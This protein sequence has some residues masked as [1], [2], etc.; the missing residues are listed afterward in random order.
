MLEATLL[1]PSCC[2]N[3]FIWNQTKMKGFIPMS[4]IDESNKPPLRENI[5]TVTM[6]G[7][8]SSRSQ[9]ARYAADE[10]VA[11]LQNE[12]PKVNINSTMPNCTILYRSIFRSGKRTRNAAL[13]SVL[14]DVETDAKNQ[15]YHAHCRIAPRIL[16]NIFPSPEVEELSHGI[17]DS[18]VVRDNSYTLSMPVQRAVNVIQKLSTK[19]HLVLFGCSRGATTCFYTSM[20]LPKEL[21]MH[22]SLVIVEAPFD[23]LDHAIDTSCWFPSLMRWIFRNFC[24]FQGE[25]DAEAAYSYHRD[26]VALRC[27]IAFV[28][29][30]RDMRVPNVCTRALIES[31]TRDLV[32]HKIPA[33]EILVLKHSNHPTMAVGCRE[34]QDAYVQFT[35]KDLKMLEKQQPRCFL[36]FSAKIFDTNRLTAFSCLR[37]LLIDLLVVCAMPKNGDAYRRENLRSS[38]CVE[39]MYSGSV[40][41]PFCY[42]SVTVPFSSGETQHCVEPHA[43]ARFTH[44]RVC[45][46]R[47]GSEEQTDAFY[48][49]LWN[50]NNLPG[51]KRARDEQETFP[52]SPSLFYAVVD[53]VDFVLPR[54]FPNARRSVTDPPFMIEDDT[55]AEHVVEIHIYFLSHLSIPPL[56]VLHPCFLHERD[57]SAPLLKT[58]EPDNNTKLGIGRPLSVRSLELCG[59]SSGSNEAPTSL[60]LSNV[61]VSERKDCIRIFHPSTAVVQFLR[62]VKQLSQEPQIER[63]MAAFQLEQSSEGHEPASWRL[64][65]EAHIETYCQGRLHRSLCTLDCVAQKLEEERKK[66]ED[67]AAATLCR[68][69]K[70]CEKAQLS[71]SM[72]CDTC[73][74]LANECEQPLPERN[75]TTVFQ[76]RNFYSLK[77]V[78]SSMHN[79][80]MIYES[81]LFLSLSLFFYDYK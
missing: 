77:A 54:G 38:R 41:I 4:S 39:V 46:I 44:K 8:T 45:Y 74:A 1:G 20:K 69:M 23:T 14:E 24:D 47:D 6:P 33:V 35:K 26:E 58:S 68:M 67:H 30:L 37:E 80:L 7:V 65:Y 42:G 9:L 78:R 21:A 29:S 52:R 71:L 10:G 16:H 59:T 60:G 11:V 61:I 25:E 13:F 43:G 66:A 57:H 70:A 62:S 36:L 76:R 31:V 5:I 53:H 81:F 50:K 72:L 63:M 51:K 79:S 3:F 32:P 73:C 2:N 64:L 56:M 48:R 49:W 15:F 34:D 75:G 28:M 22:V 17:F 18:L 40:Q 55:W 19:K 12:R 27:P